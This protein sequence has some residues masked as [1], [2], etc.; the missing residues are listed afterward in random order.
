[1]V[2]IHFDFYVVVVYPGVKGGVC[3]TESDVIRSQEECSTAIEMLTYRE[4]DDW[5]TGIYSSNIPSG[6]SA[7]INSNSLLYPHFEESA[8]GIGTG[9]LDLTPICKKSAT[10][11]NFHNCF[12]RE[13]CRNE[14]VEI[15]Q[16][17]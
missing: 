9:R 15:T 5:W 2:S 10:F 13:K 7:R 8:T 17:Y 1:M 12:K 4:A 11:G 16:N 6:C 3:N 14:D